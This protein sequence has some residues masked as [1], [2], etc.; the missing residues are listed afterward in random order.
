MLVDIPLIMRNSFLQNIF[1]YQILL[2]RQGRGNPA[3]RIQFFS[4][5]FGTRG[6]IIV[7]YSAHHSKLGARARTYIEA[8]VLA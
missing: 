2:I 7:G 1:L 8:D 6:K 5:L 3:P 4:K